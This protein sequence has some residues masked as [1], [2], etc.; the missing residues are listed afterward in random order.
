MDNIGLLIELLQIDSTSSSERTF[1]E[2]LKK[3]LPDGRCRVE[4]FEIGDGTENLL[5][6][7]GKPDIVFCTHLD[8]VPPYIAPTFDGDIVRGRGSCDAKGQ[9]FAMYNACL[10]LADSGASG[11][12]L[13]LLAGEET[14]S[15][16]AKSF[17]QN[18]PG[19]QCVIV[20]EPTDNCMVSASKGTKLFEITVRGK[21]A[22][23]G[24]PQYGNSAVERFVDF[25]ERLR[26]IEFPADSELG[27]TTYNIGRLA[28]DNPQNVLSDRLTFRLYF[29]TTFASDATV[30]RMILEMADENLSVKALGGDTPSHYLT[31]DGFPT[32]TVAFGSDAPQLSNFKEKILYGPGSILVAHTPLEHVRIADLHTAADNYVRM[33]RL[34]AARPV[35]NNRR[36]QS[37]VLHTKNSL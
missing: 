14:G 17:R 29:R 15:F 25:M 23:S 30:S 3:R 2:F 28:S 35:T 1:S 5:F 22:H 26:A 21:S 7:W 9:I 20:G 19:G 27:P 18:H 11:F 24:Y 16:G 37:S 10:T 31:L 33:F 36:T 13:L 32:T 4:S 12:G 6:S 34:L 8:T